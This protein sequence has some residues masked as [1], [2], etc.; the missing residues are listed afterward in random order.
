MAGMD[1]TWKASF[2]EYVYELHCREFHRRLRSNY[3]EKI[4]GKWVASITKNSDDISK[5]VQFNFMMSLYT[6]QR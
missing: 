1:E 4:N 2:A 6:P 5:K 3:I